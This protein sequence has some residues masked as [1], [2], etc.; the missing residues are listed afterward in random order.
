MRDYM[1][2]LRDSIIASEEARASAENWKRVRTKTPV[3]PKGTLTIL[4]EKPNT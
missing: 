2:T 3:I 1:R 4:P